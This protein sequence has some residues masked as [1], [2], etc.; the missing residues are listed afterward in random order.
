M[1]AREVVEPGSATLGKLVEAFGRSILQAD[2]TLDRPAL[3]RIAFGDAQKRAALNRI[4][5]TAIRRRMAWL[6]LRHW[7]T[8]SKV[9]VVD[10]P[11]L[12]EAGLWKWCGQAVVVWCSREDQLTRMLKRDADKGLTEEDARQRL[13]AQWDLDKKRPYADVLLDNSKPL[14]AAG[15]GAGQGSSKDESLEGQVARMVQSW[16]SGSGGV[17]GTLRWLSEWLLPPWGLFVGILTALGRQRRVKA[18]L[19]AAGKAR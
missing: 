1:I 11:L 4:T 9:V 16:R 10:T 19:Q 14:T 13:D 8:G 15:A 5:H 7:L 18:R 3:G 6:V 12:V 2:G 17:F